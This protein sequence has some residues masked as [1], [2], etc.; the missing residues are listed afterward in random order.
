MSKDFLTFNPAYILR[1]DGDRV[2]LCGD[3]LTEYQSEDWFSFIHP[4]YGMLLSFFSQSDL[5]AHEKIDNCARYFNKPQEYIKSIIAPL[6][7]NASRRT[8]FNKNGAI[9]F[10]KNTI[11]SSSKPLTRKRTYDVS[12]FKYIGLPDLDSNRLAYPLNI[13]LELTMQCHTNCIYCYANR[14]IPHSPT[15]STSRIIE[16]IHEAESNNVKN[17]DING[18]EVMLHPDIKTILKELVVCGFSPLVSTKIPLTRSELD[19]L[20]DIGLEKIQISL[21]SSDDTIL[22]KLLSTPTGYLNKIKETLAY[23]SQIGLRVDINTVLTKF[24][25][26][27][28]QVCDLLELTSSYDCVQRHRLN[29]V[30]FSLYKHNFD[31]IIPLKQTIEV[32]EQNLSIWKDRFGINIDLSYYECERMFN[33]LNKQAQFNKRAICTGNVWNMVILPNGDVTICEELYTDKRFIIGNVTNKSI[34]DVWNG[35]VALNLYNFT[36]PHDSDSECSNCEDYKSCRLGRGVCWKSIL[37]AYGKQNW[38]YPDPRCPKAP[39][40]YNKFFY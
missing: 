19:F 1:Q 3:G 26:S 32:I 35:E 33:P 20:R 24:N 4:Y 39:Y 10:P 14:N 25:S 37:M 40:P 11:I 30:G 34:G 8:L 18:G 28:S 16:L 9:Y 23:A 12:D 6:T 22:S 5:Q 21:D 29:P 2:I 38:D 7:D 31:E 15:L 27:A 36:L 13:N 17:F